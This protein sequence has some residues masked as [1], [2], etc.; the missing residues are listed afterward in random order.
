M[1]AF[2]SLINQFSQAPTTCGDLVSS[3]KLF[4]VRLRGCDREPS[5]FTVEF[6]A[7]VAIGNQTVSLELTAPVATP[8]LSLFL[9]RGTRLYRASGTAPYVEYVQLAEDVTLVEG[10]PQTGIAIEPALSV[11]AINS[12]AEILE[13]LPVTA[14]R[15]VPVEYNVTTD[16]TKRT[17]DGLK[18]NMTVTGVAPTISTEIFYDLGDASVWA[19]GF[20]LDALQTGSEIY[21]IRYSSGGESFLAGACKISQFGETDEVDATAKL[22]VTLAFQ[23]N[24]V[25]VRPYRYLSVGQKAAAQEL[26]RQLGLPQ[27]AA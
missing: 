18:G 2:S 12:T 13:V 17:V 10:V 11:I 16:N 14:A 9:K 1:T 26:R 19:E 24:Y 20:V 5:T 21:V 8:A 15:N 23:N 22:S 7:A 25:L 3:A 27:Y 6:S 4:L